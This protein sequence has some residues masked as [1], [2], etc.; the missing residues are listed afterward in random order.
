M[1]STVSWGFECLVSAGNEP[2]SLMYST[3]YLTDCNNISLLVMYSESK[4]NSSGMCFCPS[5]FSV[6]HVAVFTQLQMYICIVSLADH[7]ILLAL[8]VEYLYS[9]ETVFK[10]Y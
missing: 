7:D 4:F 5:N 8:C 2:M 10:T 9:Q 3:G 1:K 6:Q